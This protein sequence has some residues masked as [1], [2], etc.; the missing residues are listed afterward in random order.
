MVRIKVNIL[1]VHSILTRLFLH[2]FGVW[3]EIL[4]EDCLQASNKYY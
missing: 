3:M 4:E 1:I 2:V